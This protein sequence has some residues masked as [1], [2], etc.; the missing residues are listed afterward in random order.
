[1]KSKHYISELKYLNSLPEGKYK[2]FLRT[3]L[4][5]GKYIGYFYVY[6]VTIFI[7]GGILNSLIWMLNKFYGGIKK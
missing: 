4:K 5:I 3:W 7:V 2:R 6:E 1:M